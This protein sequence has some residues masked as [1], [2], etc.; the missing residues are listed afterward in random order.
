VAVKPFPEPIETLKQL[1]ESIQ[2]GKV[3]RT[4]LRW[5]NPDRGSEPSRSSPDR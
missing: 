4:I 1:M 2:N 5:V 3:G